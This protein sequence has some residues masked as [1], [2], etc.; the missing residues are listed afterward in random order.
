[1]EKPVVIDSYIA[2]VHAQDWDT[3]D[4]LRAQYQGDPMITRFNTIERALLTEAAIY[5]REIQILRRERDG[6]EHLLRSALKTDSLP[7][8]K[9]ALSKRGEALLKQATEARLTH[10]EAQVEGGFPAV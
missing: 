7:P 6:F 2:A 8:S 5:V 4:E 10:P 3:C 1:M 9:N